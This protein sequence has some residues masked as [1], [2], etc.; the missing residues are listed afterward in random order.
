MSLVLRSA[1]WCMAVLLVALPIVGVVN[2]WYAQDRWPMHRLRVSAEFRHVTLEQV[3][4]AVT[5]HLQRGFFAVDLRAVRDAVAALPWV[6]S[7]E[8]R[9]QWPDRV[10]V[11]LYEHQPYARWGRRH[12]LSTA[13]VLFATPADAEVADLPQLH[14]PHTHLAEVLSQWRQ[15]QDLLAE[16]DLE[17]RDL[18]LSTRGSW[19]LR[20]SE[21]AQIVIGR[22]DLMPRLQRF[23]RRFPDLMAMEQRALLRADLRYG[24]GFALRWADPAAPHAAAIINGFDL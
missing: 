14:G 21:G 22:D 7:V 12:L 8:V 13:G 1:A 11:A 6:A 24:N 18:R 10:E 15:V 9:K 3:R 5:V 4:A 20:L 17:A 19:S 2:G 16:R 23:V